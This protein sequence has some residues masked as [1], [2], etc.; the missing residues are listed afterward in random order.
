MSPATRTQI[1]LTVEQRARLDE[2]ARREGRSLAELIREAVDEYLAMA[3]EPASQALTATFGSMPEL[4]VPS[5]DEWDR[6][7]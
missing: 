7:G 5:R 3:P 6:R 1:Y 2:R 4:E